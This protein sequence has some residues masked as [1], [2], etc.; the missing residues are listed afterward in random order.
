MQTSAERKYLAWTAP[1]ALTICV[2]RG[3]VA[4]GNSARTFGRSVANDRPQR[5]GNRPRMMLRQALE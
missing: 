4:V 5:N 3:G 2:R 1:E